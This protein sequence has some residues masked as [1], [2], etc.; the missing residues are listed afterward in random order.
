M[1][2]WAWPTCNVPQLQTNGSA[3][4]PVQDLQSKVYSDLRPVKVTRLLGGG[5]RVCRE[6]QHT[7]SAELSR[8]VGG[9]GG[10]VVWG[11]ELVDVSLD[12]AGLASAQVSYHQDLVQVFLLALCR[13]HTQQ[14]AFTAS[15]RASLPAQPAPPQATGLMIA[16]F[17]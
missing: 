15:H 10:S 9:Y 17:L 16:T 14:D 5:A 13:L 7:H 1:D 2:Q 6:I 12:D 4:V 3:V 11:E 8:L